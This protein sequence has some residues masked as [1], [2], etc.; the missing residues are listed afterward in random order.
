MAAPAIRWQQ[1][2]FE[3]WQQKRPQITIDD[4][5]VAQDDLPTKLMRIFAGD[6]T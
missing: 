3:T 5:R 6:R 1:Y 4:M 2:L